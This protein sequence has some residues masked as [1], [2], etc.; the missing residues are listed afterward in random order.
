MSE[1]QDQAPL[2]PPALSLPGVTSSFPSR[3]QQ[4][5]GPV[6]DPR[7]HSTL[8][9][10]C[11]VR[12]H[13]RR[14]P[15]QRRSSR[16]KP[17]TPNSH[18]S[19][20]SPEATQRLARLL[21]PFCAAGALVPPDPTA[22]AR[23][24]DCSP[25]VSSSCSLMVHCRA[26]TPSSPG[27][28]P[29]PARLRARAESRRCRGQAGR[30]TAQGWGPSVTLQGHP[31]RVRGSSDNSRSHI[32]LQGRETRPRLGETAKVGDPGGNRRF[33]VLLPPVRQWVWLPPQKAKF[34]LRYVRAVAAEAFQPLPSTAVHRQ[35]PSS[36]K[37][38]Q[39]SHS[40]TQPRSAQTNLLCSH[41]CSN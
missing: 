34:C 22:Q 32:P 7:P 41:H 15:I 1:G 10:V 28:T 2:P 18:R 38:Q 29:A 37:S 4:C 30:G 40:R 39:R 27:S 36:A 16:P 23:P 5:S 19:S 33:P 14:S 35:L 17:T 24:R 25:L 13:G 6:G 20:S 11:S 8:G 12:G 31:V 26:A 3:Q 9:H 21:Q